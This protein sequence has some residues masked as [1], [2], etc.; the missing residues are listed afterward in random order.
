MK[1]ASNHRVG[2]LTKKAAVHIWL[3]RAHTVRNGKIFTAVFCVIVYKTLA[4]TVIPQR[5][6]IVIIITMTITRTQRMH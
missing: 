2:K 3:R 4:I 6:T 5:A 1:F